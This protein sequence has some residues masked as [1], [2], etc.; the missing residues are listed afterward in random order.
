[1]CGMGFCDKNIFCSIASYRLLQYSDVIDATLKTGFQ[2]GTIWSF[3]FIF[4][5]LKR[6]YMKY[7]LT[8][9]SYLDFGGL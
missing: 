4:D 5:V 1:M 8:D 3:L 2:D 6:N 9:I 7:A